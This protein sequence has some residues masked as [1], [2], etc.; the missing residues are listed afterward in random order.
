MTRPPWHFWP[1]I[2]LGTLWHLAGCFDYLATQYGLEFWLNMASEAQRALIDALPVW[3]DAAWGITV[4]AGLFGMLLMAFGLALAPLILGISAVA[5]VAATCWLLLGTDGDF[6]Q[7]AGMNS[8]WIMIGSCVA[9]VLLW[10]Y[11]R[12][13]HKMGVID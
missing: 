3:V 8:V 5:I 13:L 1:I 7:T 12:H 4:W 6:I 9:A 2:I 11:A 10:L